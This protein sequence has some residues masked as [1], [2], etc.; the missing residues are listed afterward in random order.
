[1]AGIPS[2]AFGAGFQAKTPKEAAR[3]RA[4]YEQLAA[5]GG[6]PQNVGEGLN[7]VGEA[8]LA[9]SML[10]RATA[11]E[12]AGQARVAELVSGFGDGA[13]QTEL[14]T[15]MSDPWL[16]ENPAG[17]MVAQTLLQRELK[18]GEPAWQ[19]FESGGNMYRYNENDPNSAP[20]LFFDAPDA[21]APLPEAPKVETRYNPETGMDEKVQWNPNTSTWDAFGGQKAPAQPLVTVNTGDGADS[22]LDKKLSEKE[23][24]SWAAYKTAG[25]VSASN[26]QDF[27]VLDE[28]I[29]IA[30]QGP[31]VG[32]LA[33]T[34]KGFNSAGDAFQSIVKRI[35]PTLRAPG[36]GATSDIEY[37]GMLQSLPSLKNTPE[38]NAMIASIMKAKAQI[39][40]ER[41]KLITAYQNGD[42]NPETGKPM[43]IGEARRKMNELDSISIITPEMRQALLGVGAGDSAGSGAAAPAV[44]ETVDGYQ[45]L[46]GD[47]ASPTSWKKL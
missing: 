9:R 14:M 36:S 5:R 33:E 28:L 31:I 30:P 42:I 26:A 37:D 24:E 18:K 41:S 22:I 2:F 35:A 29:K 19:T 32:P 27:A 38:G 43:T 46:G 13:D 12:E 17:S 3:N 6:A 4:V 45:F 1:M 47:P 23:G 8:L 11:G 39:N 44:G 7:R 16:A 15:A 10:D 21:P 20:S 25:T 40:I 34:F